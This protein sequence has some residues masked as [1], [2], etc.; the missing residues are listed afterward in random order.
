[1][2]ISNYKSLDNWLFQSPKSVF[3]ETSTKHFEEVSKRDKNT[4]YSIK[5]EFIL[6][7]I[8]LFYLLKK[9]AKIFRLN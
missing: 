9:L 7:V 4:L 2:I 1:M 3:S 8:L 6:F 5:Y